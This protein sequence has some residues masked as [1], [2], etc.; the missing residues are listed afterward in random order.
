MQEIKRI[1]EDL[2][3]ESNYICIELDRMLILAK[4]LII[5]LEKKKEYQ[6]KP[7]TTE[8]HIKHIQEVSGRQY[9]RYDDDYEDKDKY[10]ES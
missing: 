1:I 10:L 4:R 5:E 6:P 2:K 3:D 8:W 9:E 7:D